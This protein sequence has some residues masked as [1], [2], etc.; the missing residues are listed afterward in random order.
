MILPVFMLSRIYQIEVLTN[1]SHLFITCFYLLSNKKN[2]HQHEKDSKRGDT[3]ENNLND[4]TLITENDQS[5]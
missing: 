5:I 1:I 4:E 3:I 2:S